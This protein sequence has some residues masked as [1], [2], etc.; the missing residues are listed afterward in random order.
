MPK[1]KIRKKAHRKAIQEQQDQRA[2]KG[3]CAD[4]CCPAP[5][6]QPNTHQSNDQ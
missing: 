5:L 6:S 3:A 2:K 4:S 1:S